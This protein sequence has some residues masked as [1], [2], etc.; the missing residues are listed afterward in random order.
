MSVMYVRD[1]DGNLIPVPS[2]QGPQG[3]AGPQGP[4]GEKGEAG[5]SP[6]VTPAEYGAVGDGVA[7][8]SAAIQAAIDAADCVVLDKRYAIGSSISVPGGKTI[9]IEGT[10]VVNGAVGFVIQGQNILMCGNGT[11]HLPDTND[12]CT[13]IRFLVSGEMICYVTLRDFQILGAYGSTFEQQSTGVEFVGNE[14]A[15]SCCYIEI[16]CALRAMYRGVYTHEAEGQSTESWVTQVDVD[17][18]IENCVQA[19]N[20]SWHG[21]GSRIRGVIQPKCSTAIGVAVKDE[22]LVVL[23]K[24][25]Y[26]DSMVWDMDTAINKTAISV[27]QKYCTVWTALDDGYISIGDTAADTLTIRRPDAYFMPKSGGRFA[28]DIGFTGSEVGLLMT[29]PSGVEERVR[30]SGQGLLLVGSGYTNQL[31]YATDDDRVTVIRYLKGW[32][33]SSS[34]E[35]ENH[36]YSEGNEACASGYIPAKPGNV[37]RVKNITLM[38]AINNGVYVLAYDA[39]NNVTGVKTMNTYPATEV[40]EFELVLDSETFGSTFNAIRLSVAII[41]DNS[42]VTIN[43][44][45]EQKDTAIPVSLSELQ[46]D[47]E[48]RTVT[49]EEKTAWNAKADGSATLTLVGVDADGTEH[50]W[51]VYG[52]AVT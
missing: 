45:I 35:L 39:D 6:Y 2:I 27:Q 28:G 5:Y 9:R 47:T 36:G 38:N 16:G 29:N 44:E 24:N 22:P 51:T 30:V 1:K 8:D 15:G 10:V 32:R 14:T 19:V 25:G 43:E 31:N 33:I 17:A 7:D 4:Q 13:A 41:D 37:L 11:I 26:M 50:T 42:I 12:G 23:P 3:P 21:Q 49:D 52:K 34:G 48:H 46:D 20:F 40:H 18:T